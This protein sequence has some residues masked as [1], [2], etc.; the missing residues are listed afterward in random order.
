MASERVKINGTSS[1]SCTKK[2]KKY[3]TRYFKEWE[4]EFD[5]IQARA[6]SVVGYENKFHC[7]CCNVDISCAA[8]GANNVLKHQGISKHIERIKSIKGKNTVSSRKQQ[9]RDT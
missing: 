6:K 8:G 4:K 7:V 3:K 1:A 9:T 5:F 2:V